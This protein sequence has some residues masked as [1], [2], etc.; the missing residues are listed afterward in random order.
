[1]QIYSRWGV[2]IFES[3]DLDEGWDGFDK[4][5]TKKFPQ[6]VYIYVIKGQFRNNKKFEIKGDLTLLR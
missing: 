4:T 3:N 5:G 1:M 2:L 6:D